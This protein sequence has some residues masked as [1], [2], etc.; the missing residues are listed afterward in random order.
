MKHFPQN[1]RSTAGFTLVEICIAL[2]VVVVGIMAVLGLLG[3]GLQSS[4]AAADNCFPVMIAQ[5]IFSQC[6]ANYKS[7]SAPQDL[8]SS[9]PSEQIYYPISGPPS[10]NSA[11]ASYYIA[12]VTY[13]PPPPPLTQAQMTK[14]TV[15]VYWPY[16]PLTAPNYLRTNTF[17][18]QIAKLR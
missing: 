1:Q 12:V 5:D 2:G 13:S 6:R 14:V 7:Y 17:I 15:Q 11:A 8:S 18:T 9:V 3:S 4:R 16:N 10:T